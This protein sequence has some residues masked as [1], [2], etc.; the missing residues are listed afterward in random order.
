MIHCRE[1]FFIQWKYKCWNTSGG[2]RFWYLAW[3]VVSYVY[4]DREEPSAL[5]GGRHAGFVVNRYFWSVVEEKPWG[6]RL[7]KGTTGD[8]INSCWLGDSTL[9]ILLV[10]CTAYMT[11]PHVGRQYLR[12]YQLP[13]KFSFVITNI[14]S[15]NMC[16]NHNYLLTCF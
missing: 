10:Y 11:R 6:S 13:I 4:I 12:W 7:N 14:L 3:R 1:E 5:E 2:K 16:Y 15:Y 8:I 9:G